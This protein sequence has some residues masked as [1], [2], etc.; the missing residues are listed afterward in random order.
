MRVSKIGVALALVVAAG[1]GAFGCGQGGPRTYPVRGKIDLAGGDVSALAGSYVDAAHEGDPNVR[2]SG[3]IR[4]DGSFALETLHEGAIRRGAR[5]GAYRVRIVLSDDDPA[6]KKRARQ[7]IARRYLS[8]ETSGLS[9]K[10]PAESD[11]V[12]K[13]AAR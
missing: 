3:E 4:A 10:V 12:V 7:A 6:T 13:L 11:P 1:L 8:F 5:E 2:A 9:L